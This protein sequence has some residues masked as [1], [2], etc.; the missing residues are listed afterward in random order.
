MQTRRWQDGS[1]GDIDYGAIGAEYAKYRRPEPAIAAQILRALGD[2]ETVLNVGAGAG[3]YEPT[4]R[5][6]TAVEPS[7]TMRAQ[8]PAHL[9][10]AIDASAEHLPFPDQAFDAAMGTYTVH[11]WA[12][13]ERGMAEL[14]RVTRGPIVIMAADPDRLHDFW[15]SHYCPEALDKER[16]RFP[17]IDRIAELLGDRV[18]IETVPIPF[19]CTDGFTEA[20]Y[21]RPERFLEPAV[22]GVMSSWTM[23]DPAILE[24]FRNHLHADLASG[25][26]DRAHG[27]LRSQ[28]W[29]EGSLRLIIR[30]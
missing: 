17:T 9:T 29:Y 20:Y 2:A 1:S 24:R 5:E 21:G 25:A 30:R 7:E 10:K 6:V 28:P 23:T 14:R 18:D 26:W 8:R 4:D 3:S 27:H 16:E 11:Q 15:I 19:A 22:T 13:L 12:D